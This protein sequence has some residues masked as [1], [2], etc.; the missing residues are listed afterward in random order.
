MWF[1]VHRYFCRSRKRTCDVQVEGGAVGAHLIL[2]KRGDP[3]DSG[4]PVHMLDALLGPGEVGVGH[5]RAIA[6]VQLDVCPH[7]V[8]LATG[9]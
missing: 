7:G 2:R 4:G 6:K 1:Q 3:E 9:G 5:G 8:A